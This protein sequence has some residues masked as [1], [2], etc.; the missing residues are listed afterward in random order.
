MFKANRIMTQAAITVTPDM[1]I[2]DAIR[3]MT[4]RNL[5]A[6]PVVDEDLHLKGMLSEKDVLSLLYE[7]QVFSN[8]LVC[9]F[10][11]SEVISFDV[12]D[13]LIDLCDCFESRGIR[14]VPI[15][16]NGCLRGMVTRSDVID[17]I[18]TIQH[19]MP[20]SVV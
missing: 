10:M 3:L 18:L 15:T 5:S 1:P 19:E 6:L 8:K 11:T 13:N 4:A 17:A 16:E 14:R 12:T 20:C 9:D 7:H 2:Y